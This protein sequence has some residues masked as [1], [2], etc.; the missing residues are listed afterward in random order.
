MRNIQIKNINRSWKLLHCLLV[1]Y[2][3][4]TVKSLSLKFPDWPTN[5]IEDEAAIWISPT[6]DNVPAHVTGGAVDI[7]IWDQKYC[8]LLDMGNFGAVGRINVEAP[9]FYEEITD[10]Q[11]HNRLLCLLAAAHA[12]L[13]IYPNEFW[14]V[15]Y[16]DRY[17]TYWKRGKKRIAL[18]GACGG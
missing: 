16:G 10:K 8:K 14:H 12:G 4:Y 5:K 3:F 2:P 9:I 1:I 13:V 7:R 17:A 6:E 11:K 15:S 18:Y